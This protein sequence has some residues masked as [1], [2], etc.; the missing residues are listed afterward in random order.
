MSAR[1]AQPKNGKLPVKAALKI[2]CSSFRYRPIRF[3]VTVLLSVCAFAFLGV[4]LNIALN[5]YADV[6]YHAMER[7][8][9]EQSVV[10]DW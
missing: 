5:R 6:I 8:G 7:V 1:V 4:S 10:H 3:V 9:V 2:G